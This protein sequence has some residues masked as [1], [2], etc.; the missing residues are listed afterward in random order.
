MSDK[1]K[2]LVELKQKFGYTVRESGCCS[3]W[4]TEI[5]RVTGYCPDCNGPIVWDGGSASGCDY[6]PVMC[7]TCGHAGCTGAC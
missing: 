5:H 2:L 4:S 6:S 1:E 3:G 7:K